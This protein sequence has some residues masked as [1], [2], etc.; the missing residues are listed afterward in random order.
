MSSLG[1]LELLVLST[2]TAGMEMDGEFAGSPRSKMSSNMQILTSGSRKSD[3]TS[4]E[5]AKS[6]NNLQEKGGA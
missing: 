1:P 6:M 3:E 4:N 5:I 2:V